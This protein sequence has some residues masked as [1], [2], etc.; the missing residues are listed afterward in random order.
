MPRLR[1]RVALLCLLVVVACSRREEA[2][3]REPPSR[4]PNVLAEPSAPPTPTVESPSQPVDHEPPPVRAGDLHILEGPGESAE[5]FTLFLRIADQ[6]L[7]EGP[8]IARAEAHAGELRARLLAEVPSPYE[9]ALVI[10]SDGSVCSSPITRARELHTIRVAFGYE[11]DPESQGVATYLGLELARCDGSAGVVG[12]PI[13][14]HPLERVRGTAPRAPGELVRAV[15]PSDDD[16]GYADPL[17]PDAYRLF[18]LPERDLRVVLG[19]G[20]WAFAQGARRVSTGNANGLISHVVE[21]GWR[22]FFLIETP[23]EGWIQAMERTIPEVQ[24]ARCVVADASGT[25]LNVRRLPRGSANVVTT[26]TN[27][28]TVAALVGPSPWARVATS[29]PGWAHTS[30]M[31]CAPLPPEPWP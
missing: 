19:T 22:T 11:D 14:V 26:L 13:V 5:R 17:A 23:S 10:G 28:T 9:T 21:A 16:L 6:P 25:P 1:T 3:A 30:G 15:Q 8:V 20:A 31:R 29:P 2:P 24:R 18:E 4:S 27:A 7:P 12:A